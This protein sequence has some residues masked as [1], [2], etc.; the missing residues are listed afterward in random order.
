MLRIE[1]ASAFST[2][3][4]QH[5]SLAKECVMRQKAK[6]GPAI[7]QGSIIINQGKRRLRT[8]HKQNYA[9]ILRTLHLQS[10]NQMTLAFFLAATLVVNSWLSEYLQ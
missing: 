7:T 6:H 1:S 9:A 4:E 10:H 8:T 5:N 2:T 3:Q